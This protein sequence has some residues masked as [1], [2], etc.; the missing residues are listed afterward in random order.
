MGFPE[1]YKY[2]KKNT[3][4]YTQIGNAV[5]PVIIKN[6]YNELCKQKFIQDPLV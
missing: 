4:N 6:I 1:N 2:H 5:S 3:V